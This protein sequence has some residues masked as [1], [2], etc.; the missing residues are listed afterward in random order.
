MFPPK[1]QKMVDVEAQIEETEPLNKILPA[2]YPPTSSNT[3]VVRP[4]VKY[5]FEPRYPIKGKTE[6]ILG[7]LGNTRE[8]CFHII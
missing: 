7:V 5:T 3:D 2:T 1:Y 8:V 6:H 4:N